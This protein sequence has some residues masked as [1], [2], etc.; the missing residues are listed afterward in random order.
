MISEVDIK[1]WELIDPIMAEKALEAMPYNAQ[2]IFLKDFIMRVA[3][4]KNIQ[5]NTA[6]AKTA[7]LLRKPVAS[8]VPSNPKAA[9]PFTTHQQLKD[10]IDVEMRRE[11]ASQVWKS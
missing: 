5:V 2:Y 1:D 4:L 6:A 10:T 8:A 3:M 7:A 9:W 11:I